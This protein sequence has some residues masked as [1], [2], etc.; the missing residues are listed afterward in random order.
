MNIGMVGA[1]GLMGRGIA[2]NLLA[3][4]YPLSILAHRQREPIDALVVQGA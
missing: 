4:G 3:K 1:S 2:A